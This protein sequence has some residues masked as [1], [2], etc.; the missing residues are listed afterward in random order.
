MA[1]AERRFGEIATGTAIA[2]TEPTANTA[3]AD[4]KEAQKIADQTAVRNAAMRKYAE[5]VKEQDRQAWL[6]IQRQE[7]ETLEDG[8]EK[9][10]RTIALHYEQLTEENEKRRRQMLEALADSKTDEWL[11]ANPKAAKAQQEEYRKN[12]SG[13]LGTSDL[14][15]EQQE[16]LKAYA[17]L[18]Q[19]I[20]DKET[21]KLEETRKESERASVQSYLKEYG[22]YQEKR[23][24]LAQEAEDKIAKIRK[25]GNA[26]DADK[27]YQIKAVEKGLEQSL[28]DLDFAKLKKDINWD[29][30]FGDLDNTAPEG[31]A[32]RGR[33]D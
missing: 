33:V 27:D 16:T 23:I 18:A 29:F 28:K 15:A 10:K 25:D 20:Y 13:T 17:Q 30:V 1:E 31:H 12:L 5:S 4:G 2:G 14:T 19:E 6:D 8:Y 22:E 24:V 7:I 9:Q 26:T 21:A 32:P 11:N 3:A